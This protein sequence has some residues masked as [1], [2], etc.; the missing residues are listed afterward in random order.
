VTET[1]SDPGAHPTLRRIAPR[2]V[3]AVAA[4]VV[5]VLV[6]PGVLRPDDAFDAAGNEIQV[7][8]QI[9][10]PI[11]VGMA[12]PNRDVTLA[13]AEVR[14]DK[15]SVAASVDI[16][17]CHV[18]ASATGGGLLGTGTVDTIERSC[19]SVERAATS[20]L[21]HG[22]TQGARD[23][24]FI[25]VTPLAEGDVLIEGIKVRIGSGLFARHEH[26]G[27]DVQ[28]RVRVSRAAR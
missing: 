13:S 17:T 26:L 22:A 18:A 11:V 21:G 19:A 10:R 24:L 23:S 27:P 12:T 2:A 1:T 25:V 5:L 3:A 8:A 7:N 28:V 15:D 4:A 14:I 6:V 9:G 16:M 20:R